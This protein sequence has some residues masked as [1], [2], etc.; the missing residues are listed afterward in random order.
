M[1][2]YFAIF[3]LGCTSSSDSLSELLQECESEQDVLVESIP[4]FGCD[5][6]SEQGYAM[7]DLVTGGDSGCYDQYSEAY[8]EMIASAMVPSMSDTD[9][10][11]LFFEDYRACLVESFVSRYE[12]IC[13]F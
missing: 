5:L 1:I 3:V 6:G 2:K 8:S 10:S 13:Q 9:V 11:D 7:A 12:E 4:G